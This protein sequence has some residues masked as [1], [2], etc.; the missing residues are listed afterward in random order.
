MTEQNQ[1]NITLQDLVTVVQI[2]DACTERGAFKG[3]ELAAVSQVREKFKQ[4]IAVNTPKAETEETAE[5]EEETT[6]V[7]ETGE[8]GV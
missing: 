6:D 3:E 7:A 5:T 8:E 2:I 4:I 1:T